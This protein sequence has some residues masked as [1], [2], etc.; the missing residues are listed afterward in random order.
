MY[1]PSAWRF[2]H[3]F[4]QHNVGREWIPQVVPFL[5]EEWQ[6]EWEN[7]IEGEDLKQW[8]LRLHNKVNAKLGKYA[9]WDAMDFGIA[10]K[11]ECDCQEDKEFIFLFPWG[12]LH[13]V[14]KSMDPTALA[15]LQQFNA[16][17]PDERSRGAFFTDE[18][19]EEETVYD[20]TIRHHRRMNVAMGRPEDMYVPQPIQETGA[21][22]MASECADC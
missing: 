21:M 19:G 8:S 18:P 5:P 16:L 1:G 11:P 22:A 9:N 17:Y 10:H 7:P 2:L 20:W 14:A 6:T 13:A 12:F 15:F 4:A 3:Y